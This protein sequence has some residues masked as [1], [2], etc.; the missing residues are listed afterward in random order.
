MAAAPV[1]NGQER[2]DRQAIEAPRAVVGN[3]GPSGPRMDERNRRGDTFV[4]WHIAAGRMALHTLFAAFV[5]VWLVVGCGGNDT[6]LPEVP[7]LSKPSTLASEP[8]PKTLEEALATLQRAGSGEFLAQMRNVDETTPI[9]F[10]EGLGR[11]MRNHWGL[12]DHGPLYRDL[13]RYGLHHPDDMSGVILTSFWRRQHG[14]P[15][16]IPDQVRRYEEFWQESR[17]RQAEEAERAKRASAKIRSMMLGLTTPPVNV[18]TLKLATRKTDGLR[19]RYAAKFR[20]G[21]ILTVREYEAQERLQPYFLDPKAGVMSA[22]RLP[23]LDVIR[24]A[25]VIGRTAWF[26]GDKRGGPVLVSV[27]RS[28]RAVVPLPRA[29]QT[30]QLG[31][32][33][34]HLLA[35]Y[36][37]TIYRRA[38]A[39]WALV[40]EGATLPWSGPPPTRVGSGIYFRDEGRGEND[41]R[42]WWLDLSAPTKGLISHDKD[43][44]V[45]GSD[46][47]RWEDSPSHVFAPD[48]TMWL[49]VGNHMNGWSLLK[50]LPSGEYRAAIVHGRLAYG[51]HLMEDEARRQPLRVSAVAFGEAGELIAAGNSGLYRLVSKELV[52]LALFQ[53]THQEIRDSYGV[54]MWDW[55]PSELLQLDDQR[56]LIAGLW[57][58]VYV[59][60]LGADNRSRLSSVDETG[61]LGK[62]ITF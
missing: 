56:Y 15:L 28:A 32:D 27:D 2:A 36:S 47:P 48:G 40:Y 54:G 58:G 34:E 42:L 45:V 3:S 25:V 50:R 37:R 8:V 23:E 11:W 55:D 52:P 43:V 16:D 17:R 24:S 53:N 19:T 49:T 6:Q 21:V 14:R 4:M 20:N 62:P 59:V 18:P 39:R 51:G 61:R 38:A 12:W 26:V 29:D 33:G 7:S 9:L 1:S 57:G 30:P 22:I 41:K 31:I 5:L 35:V 10:H 60:D 13:E 46:G 44:G